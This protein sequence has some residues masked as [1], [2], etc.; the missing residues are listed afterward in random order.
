MTSP[1][2]AADLIGQ[3]WCTLRGWSST[4]SRQRQALAQAVAATTVSASHAATLVLR[5]RDDSPH[6]PSHAEIADLAAATRP[7]SLHDRPPCPICQ[8]SGY[9]SFWA[10]ATSS[11]GPDGHTQPPKMR[12]VPPTP[13][14]S[15]PQ[16]DYDYPREQLVQVARCCSCEIGQRIHRAKL[17]YYGG[18]E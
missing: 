5:W 1:R 10:I 15:V 7:E 9:E 2:S 8:D 18:R 6:L 3:H 11:P 4:S 17:A 14:H 12:R 13:D 16:I